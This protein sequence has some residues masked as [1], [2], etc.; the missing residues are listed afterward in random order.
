MYAGC[1]KILYTVF[2]K[3]FAQ[4]SLIPPTLITKKVVQLALHH[5]LTNL[6]LIPIIEVPSDI[7]VIKLRIVDII[8]SKLPTDPLTRLEIDIKISKGCRRLFPPVCIILSEIYFYLNPVDPSNS[9]G[10]VVI[11]VTVNYKPS[12]AIVIYTLSIPLQTWL[13]RNRSA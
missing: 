9:A 11:K 12:L 4:T 3:L 6:L 8:N 2:L 10:T 13:S 5:L 7:P 1:V